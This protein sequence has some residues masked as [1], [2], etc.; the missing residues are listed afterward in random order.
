MPRRNNRNKGSRT[1]SASVYSSA[2][3]SDG[4][5][6][7]VAHNKVRWPANVTTSVHPNGHLK[8]SMMTPK[9]AAQMKK[10]LNS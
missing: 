7:P 8:R 10:E 2:W 5:L 3:G 6:K 4:E 9:E 1:A